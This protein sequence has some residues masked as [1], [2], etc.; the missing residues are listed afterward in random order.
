MFP[1]N[2]SWIR[3]QQLLLGVPV[4]GNVSLCNLAWT[5]KPGESRPPALRS[6]AS[7]LRRHRTSNSRIN[8]GA[9]GENTT[10]QPVLDC[11]AVGSY[12]ACGN[13][14][15]YWNLPCQVCKII[16]SLSKK[17]YILLETGLTYWH[18]EFVNIGRFYFHLRRWYAIPWL[19]HLFRR[20]QLIIGIQF[21]FEF[22]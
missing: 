17:V 6:G 1:V 7:F 2:T 14:L 15:Q 13:F 22:V 9:A 20:S 3:E 8:C 19:P 5:T 11:F 21:V 16:H 4:G 18:I 10:S 12:I